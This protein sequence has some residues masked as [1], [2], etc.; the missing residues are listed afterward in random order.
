MVW[1]DDDSDTLDGCDLVFTDDEMVKD[2]DIDGVVLFAGIDPSDEVSIAIKKAEWED[3][4]NG[5]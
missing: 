2:E 4:A 1:E 3:L 5:L